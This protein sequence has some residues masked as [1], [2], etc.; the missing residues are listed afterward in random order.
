MEE[1]QLT[2]NISGRVRSRCIATTHKKI[3]CRCSRKGGI[4]CAFRVIRSACVMQ[5]NIVIV[6]CCH[7]LADDERA[8]EIVIGR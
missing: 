1:E 5:K 8:F 7:V 3:D 2:T 4:Y 6:Y